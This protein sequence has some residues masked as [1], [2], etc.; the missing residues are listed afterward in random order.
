MFVGGGVDLFRITCPDHGS[1]TN[2]ARPHRAPALRFIMRLED[3]PMYKVGTF[4]PTSM[5]VGMLLWYGIGS[6]GRLLS[7][8][9]KPRSLPL[10]CCLLGGQPIGAHVATAQNPEHQRFKALCLGSRSSVDPPPALV[11]TN[12]RPK[13]ANVAL[14]VLEGFSSS[15][16]RT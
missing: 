2:W 10:P 8:Y 13:M 16:N 5:Q 7:E 15:A 11:H 6:L 3:T 9:Q 12:G 4:Y 14:V 1:V